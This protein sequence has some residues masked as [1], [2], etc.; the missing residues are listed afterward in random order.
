MSFPNMTLLGVTFESFQMK[1]MKKCITV[2]KWT[3][4]DYKM[5]LRKH[6]NSNVHL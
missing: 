6:L 3:G 4:L 1:F 2:L 5:T